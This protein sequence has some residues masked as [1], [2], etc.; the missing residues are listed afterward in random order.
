[1]NDTPPGAQAPTFPVRALEQHHGIDY[2]ADGIVAR[3]SEI[4]S[5]AA[6]IGLNRVMIG[7]SWPNLGVRLVDY[8]DDL[9]LLSESAQTA[10][11]A[12][13][14]DVFRQIGAEAERLGIELWPNLNIINYPDNFTQVY[15]DAIAKPPPTADRWLRMPGI[16]GLSKQPQLCASSDSFRKLIAAQ[17]GELCRLPHVSGIECWL[18]GADCDLF[19]CECER[20]AQKSIADRIVEFSET[21][22]AA[23][24]R[25]GKKLLLRCYLGGW[26]CAL[27][28]EVW[29]EAAPRIH[30]EIEIAYKQQ[31]GDLMNWHG[32]NPLAGLLAPHAEFAEFDLQGEYRGTNYGMICSVRWQFQELIR[33][34]RAKGVTNLAC[35]GLDRA[36]PFDLDKWLFGALAQNPDLDVAAWSH[37]WAT[38]R[39][40]EAGDEVVA[41]LDDCAEIMRLSMYVRGVQWASWAVPQNLSR[42]RFI[43]FDRCAPCV[44]GSF[45]LLQ[46][47]AKNIEAIIA[48]KEEALAGVEALVPRAAA[49]K[50]RLDPA[51]FAPFFAAVSYLRLYV[52]VAGPLMETFF[53]FLA[54]E[55]TSSETSRE[56]LRIPLLASIATTRARMESAHRAIAD[57]DTTALSGMMDAAGFV[58]PKAAN[59]FL[60]PFRYAGVILDDIA[61]TIDTPSASW[62]AYYPA[63]NRWPKALR[64][65]AEL[66]RETD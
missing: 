39:Y 34:F 20:C 58:D 50:D 25:H 65:R 30:P 23:T 35:R 55:K 64:D 8:R 62:W 33:H 51:I 26:R 13:R 57:L 22:R 19:Y 17:I 54:W 16:R 1:M 45:D 11:A 15:P 56:Y 48:E 49:L 53:R 61:R 44:P 46:P 60:D 21:A 63:S 42:L 40:G 10:D 3:E 29:K 66:Y 43:L 32:P 28:T 24:S 41:V 47:T 12:E 36:H 2:L 27:E 52:T 31:H 38:A 4:L 7:E 18:T 6:K 59:K 5:R 9:P 14:R 37:E